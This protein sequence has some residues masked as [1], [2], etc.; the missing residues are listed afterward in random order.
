MTLATVALSKFI[1]FFFVFDVCSGFFLPFFCV[2]GSR[3]V[4]ISVDLYFD[5]NSHIHCMLV[6]LFKLNASSTCF[7]HHKNPHLLTIITYSP[8]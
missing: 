8:H 5:L 4:S 1:R 6:N 7:S 2:D 3:S